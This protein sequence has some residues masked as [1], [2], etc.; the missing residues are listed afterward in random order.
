MDILLASRN[1]KKMAELAAILSADLPGLCLHTL[2]EVGYTQDI[3]EDGNS[4]EANALIK[5]RAARCAAQ[6]AG[7]KNWY[8]LG[9]DSGLA[10]DALNGA[11][12]IYS[13][14][15]AGGESPS[16]D[17]DN[18]ALLL[19]NMKDV[20]DEARTARFICAIACVTPEGEE[21]VVRGAC[22]GRIL[23]APRGNGG[24]G[25]D[26]L[27]FS[28]EGGKTFSELTGEEKNAIS[29]RGRAIAALARVLKGETN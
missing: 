15:Y 27:F 1:R 22:E 19:A 10:V 9:D 4:F 7:K 13:A 16:R 21:M 25:Y 29:H 17:Q 18:N 8:G 28:T 12:G 14:R 11:P 3:Q 23:R 20:P 26:P 6:A 2:D 5:A 24:F